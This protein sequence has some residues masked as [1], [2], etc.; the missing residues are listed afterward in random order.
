M[1]YVAVPVQDRILH[2]IYLPGALSSRQ[3]QTHARTDSVL[4]D[5]YIGV[6]LAYFLITAAVA[7][8]LGR[9]G[10]ETVIVL[11]NIK[12]SRLSPADCG[13]NSFK[14]RV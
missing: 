11:Y 7:Q 4:I 2:G 10:P 8:L 3:P 1:D 14:K 9:Y 5:Y 13:I 6:H 12:S